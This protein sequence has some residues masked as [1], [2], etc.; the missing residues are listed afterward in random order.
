MSTVRPKI[1]MGAAKIK[2]NSVMD[3]SSGLVLYHV[4]SRETDVEEDLEEMSW[5]SIEQVQKA[6]IKEKMDLLH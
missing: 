5:Q 2:W 6:F 1:K 3:E 4:E